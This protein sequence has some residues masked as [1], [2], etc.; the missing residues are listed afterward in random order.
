[1]NFEQL[2]IFVCLWDGFEPLW[3][4][5]QI[6]S[7]FEGQKNRLV[8]TSY[9][10]QSVNPSSGTTLDRDLHRHPRQRKA[11]LSECSPVRL[12]G[13]ACGSACQWSPSYF[14]S[15]LPSSSACGFL[16]K[17]LPG[18]SLGSHRSSVAG[19]LQQH[20]PIDL[21]SSLPRGVP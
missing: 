13:R 4:G 1:M 14:A 12:R 16:S 3:P 17:G 2:V 18:V 21:H 6:V 15:P 11:S 9:D 7:S 10:M 19:L 20:S 5:M 8:L